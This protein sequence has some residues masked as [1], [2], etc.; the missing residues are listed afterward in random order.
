M[1]DFTL[2]HRDAHSAARTGEFTTPH[3]RFRTPAFMPVGTRATVKGLLPR[4]LRDLGCEVLLAN[5]YHLALRPGSE[6][7]RDLGGLH[8]MMSWDGPILTDSGGFQVFSLARLRKIDD[9]GV[10]F[11]SHIDGAVLRMTPESCMALQADLGADIIM[12][13]DE[14]P[15]ATASRDEVVEATRRTQCWAVRCA[16]AQRSPDRQALFPIVQGGRFADLRAQAAAQLAA[17]VPAPGYAIG[18]VSVGESHELM[19]QA[20][21]AASPH[22]PETK[23]RYLMG[24]GEPRDI[25]GAIRRGVDMFDCVMPTRNG[26][27][28]EAFTFG[29]QVRMRNLQY[30]RDRGPIEPGCDCPACRQFTRGAIRHFFQVGEMLGPILVSLHNLRFFMRFLDQIRDAIAADRLAE[31]EKEFLKSVASPA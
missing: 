8:A 18:G 16:A 21:E 2:H 27:N 23:P 20:I 12:A 13:L 22:L 6:V 11:N 9:E 15:P 28:A 14:C 5:T 19:M 10:E 31:Y 7:V 24:V 25:L 29:G 26:R 4:D 1:F 3:G 17:E 30:E